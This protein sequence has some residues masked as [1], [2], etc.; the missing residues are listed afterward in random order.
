MPKKISAS[1]PQKQADPKQQDTDVFETSLFP[2]TP[3]VIMLGAIH[4]H[5]PILFGL[6]ILRG[7]FINPQYSFKVSNVALEAPLIT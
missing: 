5:R 1:H 3:E 4:Y 2:C 6:T 7:R